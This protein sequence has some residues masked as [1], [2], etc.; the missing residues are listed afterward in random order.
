MCRLPACAAMTPM[1][2]DQSLSGLDANRTY[3]YCAA[4]SNDAGAVF[5][6]V[7]SFTT[8]G[9]PPARSGGAK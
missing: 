3:Y 1:A 5:G 4:A 7:L 6:K 8:K 2:F 9:I